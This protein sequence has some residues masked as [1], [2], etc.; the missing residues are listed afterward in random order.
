MTCECSV[1]F[2]LPVLII[3][4]G[5]GVRNG[6]FGDIA[7]QLELLKRGIAFAKWSKALG[8]FDHYFSQAPLVPQ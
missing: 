5:W 1:V 4:T 6:R 8:A 7:F 3:R 2:H